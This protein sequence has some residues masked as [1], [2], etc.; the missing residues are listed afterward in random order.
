[1]TLR[2][3]LQRLASQD[4]RLAR[5][6][7]P[8]L[9]RPDYGQSPHEPM[10]KTHQPYMAEPGPRRRWRTRKGPGRKSNGQVKRDLDKVARY[11]AQ[12][13]GMVSEDRDLPGW[14]QDKVN[15]ARE[16]LRSVKHHLEYD[17]R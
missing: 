10:H 12:L 15:Q 4:D 8:L 7:Q 6:L 11:T 16:M 5:L 3:K 13:Q 17:R 2:A 1:M 9:T 14:V